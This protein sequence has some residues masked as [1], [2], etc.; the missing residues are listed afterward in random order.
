MITPSIRH[1]GNLIDYDSHEKVSLPR[2]H[3]WSHIIRV[4]IWHAIRQSQIIYSDVMPNIGTFDTSQDILL[5]GVIL[6]GIE[7]L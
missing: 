7:N 3:S 6:R 5:L 4:G 1:R 2:L